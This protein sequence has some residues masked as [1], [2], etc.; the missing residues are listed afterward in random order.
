MGYRLKILFANRGGFNARTRLACRAAFAALMASTA[1]SFT[2][3]GAFRGAQDSWAYNSGWNE[4]MMGYRNQAWATKAWH[5]RKHHFC[6]HQ[7]L[8]EFYEGFRAGYMDV[9]DGG[10]GCTPAFPPRQYWSWKYQSAEGQQKVSAWYAGYPHGA[11]AAEEDGI[12]NWT[13]IQTSYGIQK[14]YSQHGLMG[15]GQQPGMYP[16]PEALPR[17]AAAAKAAALQPEA[18][19]GVPLANPYSEIPGNPGVGSSSLIKSE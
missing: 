6:N 4:M 15:E 11:R 1:L 2:G 18:V 3:C 13:Q 14:E 17:G 16:M 5:R 7:H 12:G 8:H 9:A 19:T 10:T